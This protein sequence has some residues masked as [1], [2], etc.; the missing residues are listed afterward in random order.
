MMLSCT[1]DAK[2][3]RYVTVTDI[4]GAFIH[5]NIEQD[6]HMLLEGITAELIIKIEPRLYRKYV[7]KNKHDKPML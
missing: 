5:T 1:I 4:P 6:G 3:E 7:W 2:E